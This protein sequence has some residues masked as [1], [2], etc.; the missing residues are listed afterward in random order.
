MKMYYCEEY[1]IFA[2]VEGDVIWKY[3][4]DLCESKLFMAAIEYFNEWYRA[5]N[6]PEIYKGFEFIG[7]I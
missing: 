7:E 1:D 3:V 5:N 2:I 4:G 6:H